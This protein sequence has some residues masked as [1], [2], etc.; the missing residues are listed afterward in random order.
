MSGELIIRHVIIRGRVQGVGFRAT[1]RHTARGFPVTG[2]V[3]NDPDGAV[4][5]EVQGLPLDLDAFLTELRV[6]LSPFIA[7]ESRSTLPI[8]PGEPS[9]DILR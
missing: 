9:F 5:C 4:S 1:T 2:W 8:V 3:R 6:R 7:A